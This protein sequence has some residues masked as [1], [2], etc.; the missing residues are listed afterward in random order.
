[1]RTTEKQIVLSSGQKIF[2]CDPMKHETVKDLRGKFWFGLKLT[3]RHI[4]VILMKP[5]GNEKL[6]KI[7]IIICII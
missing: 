5:S 6:F 4:N 1:M 2:Q 3:S 7:I